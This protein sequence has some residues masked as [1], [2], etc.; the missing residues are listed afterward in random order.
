MGSWAL[1]PARVLVVGGRGCVQRGSGAR[2]ATGGRRCEQVAVIACGS[3]SGA[4][5]AG[6]A[7]A[8]QLP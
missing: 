7:F 2:A 6:L 8:A 1:R 3:A 5:C 4:A